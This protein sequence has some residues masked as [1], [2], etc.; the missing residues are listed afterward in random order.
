MAVN[1]KD[2]FEVGN[3]AERFSGG[4]FE[5]SGRAATKGKK[6]VYHPEAFVYHPSR[7]TYEEIRKREERVAYGRGKHHRNEGG[8]YA[9]LLFA[10]LL[11]IFKLSTQISYAR[12]M[13]RRGAKLGELLRFHVGF[14][15]IR[16][17]YVVF[18]TR[19]FYGKNPR[20]YG[21]K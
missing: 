15:W 19:G 11:R 7:K 10:Y 6:I 18:V 17:K 12:A 2:F 13:R 20:K 21:I 9:S 8:K 5:W 4:D 3:F 1:A 16:W 14:L